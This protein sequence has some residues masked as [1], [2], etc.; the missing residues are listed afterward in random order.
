MCVSHMWW[1]EKLRPQPAAAHKKIPWK[2]FSGAFGM[3]TA[4]QL[5][6]MHHFKNVEWTNF[7]ETTTLED[8][9]FWAFAFLPFST[10][11]TTH[12]KTIFHH[13]YYCKPWCA[14]L[15]TGLYFHLGETERKCFIEEISDEGMV[16]G[17]YK[18]HYSKV[19]TIQYWDFEVTILRFTAARENSHLLPTPLASMSS[20]CT[21]D[22][23]LACML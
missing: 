15:C 5:Q 21:G 11:Q 9:A 3:S 22:N 7:S 20:A 23:D 6:W 19:Y 2:R 14:R 13:T 16:T 1:E 4:E 17:N 8:V 12:I 18:V 10:G